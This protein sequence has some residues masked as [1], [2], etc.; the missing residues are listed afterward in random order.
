LITDAVE[1]FMGNPVQQLIPSPIISST[2]T[3][4]VLIHQAF[5]AQYIGTLV[6][7]EFVGNDTASVDVYVSLRNLDVLLISRYIISA[8]RSFKRT[9]LFRVLSCYKE[10]FL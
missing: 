5:P 4:G 10:L 7:M 8:S 6:G 9:R 2:S 1:F 3:A